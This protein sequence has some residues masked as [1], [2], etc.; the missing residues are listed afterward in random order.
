MIVHEQNPTLAR[1][2]RNDGLATHGSVVT[3]VLVGPNFVPG[4]GIDGDN[5][6]L[7]HR[8]DLLLT[9]HDGHDR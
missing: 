7:A 9:I 4:G 6:L 3:V 2:N 8:E 5:R 1:G